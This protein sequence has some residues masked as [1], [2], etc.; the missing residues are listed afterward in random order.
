MR[1]GWYAAVIVGAVVS[2]AARAQA[3]QGD[4]IY[5]LAVDS[6]MYPAQ[7][8]VVLL[9]ECVIRMEGYRPTR[10]WRTVTQ[11]LREPGVAPQQERQIAY[12]PVYDQVTI[13]WI[14][15]VRPDGTVISAKPSQVE[16]GTVERA[17]G[18]P[19]NRRVIRASLSGV[20]PGTIVDVS[21]TDA[22]RV[23]A[24][25]FYQVW[26]V[27][28]GTAVRRSR[29]TVDV[30]DYLTLR[31]VEH[32]LNFPR[33]E[34]QVGHR[35]VYEWV[36]ADV[37]WVTPEAYAPP[38]DSNDQGM[39]VTVATPDTWL[40]VGQWYAG[41]VKGSFR[42][43]SRLRDTVARVVARATTHDDSIKAVH[44]WVAQDVRSVSQSFGVGGYRPRSPDEVMAT[45]VGDSRDK[46]AL[47]IA[48]LGV[49]G[50][51]AYPALIDVRG[52]TE[53]DLPSMTTFT[54]E[55]AA[56]RRPSSY[57]FVDPT[58]DLTPL[59]DLPFEDEGQFAL[60]VH[61]DGQTEEI[62]TPRTP[63]AASETDLR[64]A[65]VLDSS[66][67]FRGHVELR[68]R[69]TGALALR[70]TIRFGMDS[71]ARAELLREGANAQF[72]D[73]TGDSLVTSDARD[74]DA[75]PAI[76]FAMQVHT[77]RPSRT[78]DILALEDPSVAAA[79]AADA[80][81]AHLPRRMPIDA[82]RV[83]DPLTAIREI[84]MT[85]PPGWRAR[86]PE[87][88][89]ATSAFGSYEST[90]QQVGRDLIITR[91]T[92]GARG[93]VSKDHIAELIAWCRAMARDRVPFVA[94]DH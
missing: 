92:T 8:T 36:T 58:S 12:N 50:V 47:L 29:L 79:A 71:A 16:E 31:F 87:P 11:V 48:A 15:V 70:E 26:R 77:T 60:V 37:P 49:I 91:R 54:R 25:N 88:V 46:V 43:T 44:R 7:S 78:T 30:P 73:A 69:G 41:Y 39:V 72:P 32:N 76:S 53:P 74:L 23:P 24:R 67:T 1:V 59:G 63:I 75:E 19:D 84:R 33:R 52:E 68:A 64:I 18:A 10:T 82:A 86:L 40:N 45:G 66:G 93:I 28:E 57:E 38:A 94:I 89:T 17:R 90:Y 85:L 62:T 20:A 80:L 14:R 83:V 9:H 61:P 42:A 6:A 34:T 2:G 51:D 13:N 27:T 3:P 21:W 55:L 4:S 81:Q 56:I 22:Q 35:L 65:G 5:R